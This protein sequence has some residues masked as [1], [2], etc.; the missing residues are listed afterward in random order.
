MIRPLS[1]A[2]A[3]ALA[4]VASPLCRGALAQGEKSE[5]EPQVIDGIAAV[6]NG[7]II[8]HSQ[9]RGVVGP[10]ERLLRSQFKGEELQKQLKEVREAAL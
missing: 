9:V 8:T 7:D 2:A 1:L 10:R 4:L 3:A 6:V 5:K